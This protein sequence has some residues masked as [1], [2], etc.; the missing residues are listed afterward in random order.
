MWPLQEA[1]PVEDIEELLRTA[2]DIYELLPLFVWLVLGMGAVFAVQ[3]AWNRLQT[4][5][6]P[7]GDDTIDRRRGETRVPREKYTIHDDVD[8]GQYEYREPSESDEITTP[9]E[10]NRGLVSTIRSLVDVMIRRGG[11]RE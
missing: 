1:P 8:V 10:V 7:P 6:E 4:V 5:S 3:W 11:E 9:N 2:A